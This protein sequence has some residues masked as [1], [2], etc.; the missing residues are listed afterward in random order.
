[1][2]YR[3]AHG[4]EAEFEFGGEPRYA[5]VIFWRIDGEIVRGIVADIAGYSELATVDDY[6]DEDHVCTFVRYVKTGI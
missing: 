1:M 2:E 6:G 5:P 4:W 3:E